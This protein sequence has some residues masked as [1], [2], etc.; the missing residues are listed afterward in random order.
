MIKTKPMAYN[1]GVGMPKLFTEQKGLP[2]EFSEYKDALAKAKQQL[3]EC[4]KTREV[5]FEK[6]REILSGMIQKNHWAPLVL[7]CA[8]FPENWGKLIK[9]EQ[10]KEFWMNELKKLLPE[11]NDT[12]HPFDVIAGR[13]CSCSG[14]LF[15]P[16]KDRDSSAPNSQR[17]L[18]L[19]ALLQD[20]LCCD[21]LV[22]QHFQFWNQQGGLTDD[23]RLE[24]EQLA[25]IAAKTDH[26]LGHAL[27]AMHY[28]RVGVLCGRSLPDFSTNILR[29][30]VAQAQIGIQ[31]LHE[32]P[33]MPEHDLTTLN[34]ES[35][36]H[37]RFQPVTCTFKKSGTS[38]DG[39]SP[40][41]SLEVIQAALLNQE[42]RCAKMSGTRC[43]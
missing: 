41:E 8:Y 42:R 30:A 13:F 14:L 11:L 20:Y 1:T 23:S 5:N 28:Y 36:I 7:L 31:K 12:R 4:L 38:S 18:K 43:R 27:L 35:H 6:L 26:A 34:F 21:W 17:W 25:S 10:L 33:T 15:V 37:V 24:C 2:A 40:E 9:C 19:G 29:L 16:E 39:T 32:N 22:Y 3:A